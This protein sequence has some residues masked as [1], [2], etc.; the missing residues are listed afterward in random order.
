MYEPVWTQCKSNCWNTL[1]AEAISDN[2]DNEQEVNIEFDNIPKEDEYFLSYKN[3]ILSGKLFD[4]LILET[5]IVL[6]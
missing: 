4:L 1:L 5:L 2:S 6:T 3:N